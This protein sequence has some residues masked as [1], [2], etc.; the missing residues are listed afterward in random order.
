LLT[1]SFISSQ[2]G[3]SINPRYV[4]LVLPLLYIFVSKVASFSSA[5]CRIPAAVLI[6]W[7]VVSSLSFYPYSM[8]YFNEL[9]GKPTNYPKYLLGSN[10]DWGQDAYALKAWIEKHPEAKPLYVSYSS[11]I[12]LEKL[13]IE[14]T[15]TIPTEPTTGWIL[16]G[17]NELFT[18]EGKLAWLHQHEPVAMI[19]YSIWVYTV[20]E[21]DL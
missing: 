10:I 12:S 9:A 16:I 6:A 11:P 20:N 15:G 8:S 2:D 14:S 21:S 19:G 1:F 7:I 5:F 18:K 3:L 13:D 17:V 4:V